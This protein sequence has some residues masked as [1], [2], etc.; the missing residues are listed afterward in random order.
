MNSPYHILGQHEKCAAYFCKKN[1]TEENRVPEAEKCGLM[2]EMSIIIKRV[3]DYA[4]SLILDVTNNVCE[5]FNSV[6]N[7]YIG[8][9][10]I[11]FSLKQSY[12]T[13]IR[14]AI[15]SFNSGGYFLRAIHKNIM[16][17]SPGNEL[18]LFRVFEKLQINKTNRSC[19]FHYVLHYYL[20]ITS[21]L[22]IGV[23]GK[24][25]LAMK[26]KKNVYC[27]K[28]RLQFLTRRAKKTKC[29]GPDEFY[30]LA[31]PLAPEEKMTTELMIEKKQQFIKHLT[32]TQKEGEALELETRDQS[33]NQKWYSE[34]RNRLTASNFGKIIKMR[35]TT[36]C[37]NIVYELLY[38]S[39]TFNSKE[40]VQ[41]R[42][43]KSMEKLA[44]EKFE[45]VTNLK[46]NHC[47]LFIDNM[48]P[49]L[50]ASPGR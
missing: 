36:S 7:K 20:D 43:G 13:R 2:G 38:N 29:T 40:P 19:V 32:L 48:L 14:A 46:V 10:R 27:V 45:E 5:Q 11:N 37:R 12:S 33:C 18:K 28:R 21:F 24:K 31:E 1:N 23:V 4:S 15:I 50:G 41:C 25:F 39:S 35:P 44:I 49:Y 16:K 17:K 6:V 34:R 30:G 3:V 22:I 47:G 9:K 42:Y 8:G 26:N